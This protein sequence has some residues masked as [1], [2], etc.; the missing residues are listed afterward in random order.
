MTEAQPT[1]KRF[2]FLTGEEVEG[3]LLAQRLHRSQVSPEDALRY[4]LDLGAYLA[5]THALSR[6]HCHVSPQS[7]LIDAVGRT[8]LVQ[9]L[10]HDNA[11][12]EYRSP[13]QVS[14]K[15]A[16]ACSDIYSFGA[17]LYRLAAGVPP[18]QG[19]GAALNSAILHTQPAP[20]A[21]Q[22]PIHQAMQPVIADCLQKDPTKRRQ[23]IQ[24]AVTELKLM[25]RTHVRPE[26]ASKLRELTQFRP[27]PNSHDD[28][29]DVPAN[30][31]DPAATQAVFSGS[32]DA[33]YV[34]FAQT[35]RAVSARR[36]GP[37][38]WIVVIALAVCAA[39][40]AA[41]VMYSNRSTGPVY[42][43][44]ID[45]AEAKSPGM[46]AVSPDGRTL[47]FT[48]D[49]AGGKR[50]LWVQALDGTHPKPVEDT[51]GAS[52]P[53]W[54]PDGAYVGFFANGVLKKIRIQNG[55]P[56]G[57]PVD[58][59]PVDNFPGGGTWSKD[60][61][62]VFASK[63]TS[64]L[65]KVSVARRNAEPLTNLDEAKHER[66]H[67]WPQF[68]PDGR[69]FIF[70]VA[71]DE[72]DENTG[73]YIGSLDSSTY[74]KL[75]TAETNAVYGGGSGSSGHLLYI[76]DGNLVGRPFQPSKLQLSGDALTLA[77][78]VAPVESLSL[79]Q[80]SASTNGT[81]VYEGA[82]QSTRQLVWL[83]RS[84][85]A[86]G[87]VGNPGD[88]GPPRLSPDAKRIAAGRRDEKA[89]AAVIWILD[90]ANGASYQL[91][92]LRGGS[93]QPVWSPDGSRIAF[94][95]DEL[96]SYDL[97][98]QSTRPESKAEL[99]YRTANRK[100]FDDWTR[101]DRGL[102]F[103]EIIPGMNRGLWLLNA[104]DHR[105]SIVLD[106]IHSEGYAAVSPDGR[107]LAYQSD[108]T[109]INQI[110]VQPYD[111]GSSGSKRIWAITRDGGGLP[112]WRRDS[113]ELFYITQP[114]EIC[115]VAVHPHGSDFAYDPPKELFQ[116]RPTPH[117]WN[118]YDVA[119]NGDRFLVNS[120]MD[121]SGSSKIAG[122][123]NW[124]KAL[125]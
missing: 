31:S 58:I 46:P 21:S 82:G 118:L 87:T 114:G 41:M 84:G 11:G 1:D 4:A 47:A 120:P 68:L 22:H 70:F 105:A 106:T 32:A 81:L 98:I 113:L 30:G 86:I 75:L 43:F 45:S 102:V 69:H 67:L 107:W 124:Q 5:K 51:E 97:Y 62:I 72:G 89:G 12:H 7:I 15:Q 64:G 112:K 16:D 109:G 9:P 33:E 8:V 25:A 20:L 56:S 78:N 80:V 104:H 18:F 36:L 29:G 111:N 85:K 40:I 74:K 88:W 91:T 28:A 17:V 93:A 100:F 71:A 52:E 122:I 53:F 19:E 96:G 108:E 55:S 10:E 44:T 101:D 39:G 77:D 65:S 61:V 66:A 59:C 26:A 27:T 6:L 117:S 123:I 79:A 73:V 24:N 38:I 34:P 110:V 99:V 83:D 48:A 57:A 42:R 95:N 63:L 125:Q 13:E 2:D 115:S 23:R 35:I 37:G 116:T 76:R 121:W 3:E 60:G 92:H 50:T 54:S 119:P 103:D 49:G 94:S 14:G 90:T